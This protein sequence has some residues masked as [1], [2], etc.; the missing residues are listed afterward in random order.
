MQIKLFNI[1]IDSEEIILKEMNQFLRS[2]R[3]LSVEQHLTNINSQANWCFCIRYLENESNISRKINKKV[4]YKNVLNSDEFIKFSRLRECRK[5]IAHEDG[6]PAYAIFT[7]E[8][9]AGI[10]QLNEVSIAT[11]E[12]IKGIGEKKAMKYGDRILN[13][14]IE[15][16]KS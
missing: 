11:L 14:L 10:A 6:V 8:E 16:E 4:D 9:M 15:T 3:I 13:M 2:K 1:P 5:K 12:T 7:D